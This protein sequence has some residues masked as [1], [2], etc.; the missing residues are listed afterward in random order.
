[1]PFKTI[2]DDQDLTSARRQWLRLAPLMRFVF[3]ASHIS[4]GDGAH[5][6]AIMKTALNMIGPPV[7]VPQ[8]PIGALS[9]EDSAQLAALLGGLGYRVQERKATAAA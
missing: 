3:R 4:R 2:A 6:A 5:W 7:G 9:E 1:M 8:P